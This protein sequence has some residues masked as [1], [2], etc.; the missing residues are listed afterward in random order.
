M[1]IS[2]TIVYMCVDYVHMYAGVCVCGCT[3]VWRPDAHLRCLYLSWF[4]RHSLNRALAS[5]ARTDWPVSA[6]DP[7]VSASQRT[8]ATDVHHHTQ[9]FHGRWGSELKSLCLYNYL[10]ITPPTFPSVSCGP[11]CS[12][13]PCSWGWSELLLLPPST[14]VVGVCHHSSLFIWTYPLWD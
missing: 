12:Q 6:N 8:R 9:L 14:L 5:S 2:L 7:P 11:G 4:L 1:N 10:L 3:C 13:T